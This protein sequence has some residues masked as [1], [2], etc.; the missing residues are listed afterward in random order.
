MRL[1][2]LHDNFKFVPKNGELY[3]VWIKKEKITRYFPPCNSILD[4]ASEIKKAALEIRH[5]AEIAYPE[6]SEAVE[7]EV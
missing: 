2:G 4:Y 5:S 7:L 3:E 6:I 1:D